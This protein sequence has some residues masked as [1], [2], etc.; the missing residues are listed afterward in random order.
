MNLKLYFLSGGAAA[1]LVL[2]LCAI[3]NWFFDGNRK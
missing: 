3:L 1:L 2:I